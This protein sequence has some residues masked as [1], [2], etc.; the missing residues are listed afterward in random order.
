MRESRKEWNARGANGSFYL[1][2]LPA[3]EIA[4]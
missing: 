1:A 3:A 4:Y 2:G